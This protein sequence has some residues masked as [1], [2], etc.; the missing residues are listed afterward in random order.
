MKY[1]KFVILVCSYNNQKWYEK[2][3]LSIL[4]QDY[5]YFR[6]I[7]TD[8]AST[9]Q[10][11]ELVSKFLKGHDPECKVSLIR[12][13]RNTKQTGNIYAMAHNCLDN[14]NLVTVDGDDWLAHE[15][16]LTKLNEDCAFKNTGVVRVRPAST[17]CQS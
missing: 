9:D 10:T 1:N 4:N 5:P 16:V 8:D 7:N 17:A 2:N 11:A 13:F 14:E 15:N 12:N 6:V 3:L